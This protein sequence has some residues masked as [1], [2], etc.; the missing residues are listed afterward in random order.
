MSSLDETSKR[1]VRETL[2]ST[3]GTIIMVEHGEISSNFFSHV[4]S[5]R[6]DKSWRMTSIGNLE[7]SIT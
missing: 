4:L 5:I 3:V 1:F 2:S 7:A 6:P